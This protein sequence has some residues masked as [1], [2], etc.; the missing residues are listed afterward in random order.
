[1]SRLARAELRDAL[2]GVDVVEAPAVRGRT[3]WP[4]GVVAVVDQ[5]NAVGRVELVPAG[6]L[7]VRNVPGVD[8]GPGRLI[9]DAPPGDVDV[10]EL[11]KAARRAAA[12][13]RHQRGVAVIDPVESPRFV[14]R[15]DT[16]PGA[17]AAAVS[18]LLGWSAAEVDRHLVE[19]PGGVVFQVDRP[20]SR[21]DVA[22]W[23]GAV[24]AARGGQDR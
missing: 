7:V 5:P 12:A 20:V 11:T 16:A 1:M 10:A 13:L 8:V 14:A 18:R 6:A 22:A 15:F 4:R 2:E 19:Y 3:V 17:V 9:W 21:A 23:V 24:V